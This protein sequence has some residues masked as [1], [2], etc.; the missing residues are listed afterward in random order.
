MDKID[1]AIARLHAEGQMTM[2]ELIAEG[3]DEA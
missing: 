2:E 1:A 3:S